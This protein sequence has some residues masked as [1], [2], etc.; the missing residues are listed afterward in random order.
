MAPRFADTDALY[1]FLLGF[2]NVERGQKTVFKLDRM[3]ALCE[4]LRDPQSACRTIHVAGSKGKGSVSVMIARLI[5][6]SGKR[7]GLYTSPHFAR[8]KERISLAGD[9]LPDDAILEAADEVLPLV[10][11]ALPSDF[12]GDELPTYF[13]LTTLI[14]FCAFRREGCD[15]AVIETGLGG[16]L[17]STNVIDSSLSVITPIELEHTE[18]LGDSI[19][20]IAAEKAGIIKPGSPCCLSAQ[21]PEARAV[22]ARTCAERASPLREAPLLVRASGISMSAE[23][24]GAELRFTSGSPLDGRF[25]RG[26]RLHSPMIGAIQADNMA[27][28]LLAAAEA[29]PALSEEAAAR[30]MARAYLPARFQ[31]LSRDPPVIL[32]GAHT[33][34]SLRRALESLEALFPG[35]KALLFACAEDK[36]HRSMAEVIG[37]SFDRVTLTRPGTFKKGDLAAL[38]AS[39]TAVG[40][41][42]RV[43][44]DHAEAI[45]SAREEAA[46]L[47][48]PLLVT[49]SFYLCSE[50]ARQLG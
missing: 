16:R 1:S 32:D 5:E 23:G 40:A 38:S 11:G 21:P 19:E 49:G 47:G 2:V 8:W 35:P 48:L 45:A 25:P 39:F 14:A 6:A 46:T 27:L 4:R 36:K 43:I 30:G 37:D 31:V 44:E 13:E 50:F 3:R 22:F 17:D 29:E 42:Y 12:P 18:W 33:P 28:A 9:D 34:N 15:L 26:L 10:D 41:N 20:L 7:V 24:T